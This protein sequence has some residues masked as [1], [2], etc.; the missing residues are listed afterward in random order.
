MYHPPGVVRVAFRPV[1]FSKLL[2]C[3]FEQ[4]VHYGKTDA[5]V[6]LRVMRALGDIASSTHDG[7][8]LEAVRACA[9]KVARI[10]KGHL[11][12]ESAES[13]AERLRRVERFGS[14]WA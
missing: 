10:C 12:E 3:A 14:R 1:P 11:P 8:H 6:M 2:D 5:A 4:I 13:F 9:R 7:A